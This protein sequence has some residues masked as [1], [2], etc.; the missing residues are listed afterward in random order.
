MARIQ[1]DEMYHKFLGIFEMSC[2]SILSVCP[3][4][5]ELPTVIGH[6]SKRGYLQSRDR[7]GSLYVALVLVG[8]CAQG[9]MA[10]EE[11]LPRRQR[12]PAWGD[13]T[14]A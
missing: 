10:G 3:I 1:L 2:T 5:L 6:V 9:L 14:D 4:V 11:R 8:L 12:L 13:H 7:P